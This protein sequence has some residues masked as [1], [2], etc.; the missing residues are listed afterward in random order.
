MEIDWDE[1]TAVAIAPQL[2]GWELVGPSAAGN[3]AAG[4][5]AAGNSAAGR[6]VEVEA[7][8]PHDPASHT[9][10]GKTKRN[11]TMF[12]PPGHLYSYLIYGMHV[13]ANVVVGPPGRGA[14]VLIRALE[15]VEG[16]SAMIERRGST[17]E[18][19]LCSGPG[20]L[21]QALGIS[22]DH[23]G[24]D[25]FDS[26]S[27]VQLRPPDQPLTERIVTGPRIGITKAVDQ[28]WR[29]GLADSPHLSRRFA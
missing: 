21:C 10:R 26:E 4:N 29:F 23:D 13:C 20:K 12:G 7:Y 5:S 16:V 28:P 2:L 1:P 25:L 14:A 8:E 19:N 9:F 6:I 17:A 27:L 15:P 11:A 24:L 3:S 18:L 22:L